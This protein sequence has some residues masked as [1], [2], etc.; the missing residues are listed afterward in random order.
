VATPGVAASLPRFDRLMRPLLRDPDAGADTIV[1]LAGSPPAAENA[2]AFWHD[3]RPRPKHR[4]PWTRES[5]AERAI[6]FD[7]CAELCGIEPVAIGELD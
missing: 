6:L 1:W 5:P 4:V 7:R 2:G 3:R